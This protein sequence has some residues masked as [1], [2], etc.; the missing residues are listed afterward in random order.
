MELGGG[1][2]GEYGAEA[3]IAVKSVTKAIETC[4][5]YTVD[6]NNVVENFKKYDNSPVTSMDFAL[7]AIMSKILHESFPSA[8]IIG[9]E[10]SGDL[11]GNPSVFEQACCIY[12]EAFPDCPSETLKRVS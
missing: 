9:E 5:K 1:N 8:V 7:Q 12:K 10:D 2:L 11:I 3:E 4:L 6:N